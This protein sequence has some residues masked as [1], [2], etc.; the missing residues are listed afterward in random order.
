M[1]KM[2][3]WFETHP[4]A[5]QQ[6]K[7]AQVIE[8]RASLPPKDRARLVTALRKAAARCRDLANGL[9]AD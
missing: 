8:H 7:L 3:P 1:T 6:R 2:V 9:E 5:V 4:T